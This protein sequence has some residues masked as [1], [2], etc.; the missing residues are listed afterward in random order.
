MK[1]KLKKFKTVQELAFAN[2]REEE[3][4]REAIPPLGKP[5]NP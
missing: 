4:V 2:K 3:R 5:R 1:K